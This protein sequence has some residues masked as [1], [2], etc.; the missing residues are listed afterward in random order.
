M[1]FL[2][3]NYCFC[4]EFNIHFS[5]PAEK[6][7]R[8]RESMLAWYNEK[9]R[10]FTHNTMCMNIMSLE[11][12]NKFTCIF[13]IE[14]CASWQDMGFRWSNRNAFMMQ[15]KATLEDLQIGYSLPTQP[16]YTGNDIPVELR[17]FGKYQNYGAKGYVAG[18][19]HG[20][21]DSVSQTF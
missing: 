3:S 19:P 21:R 17:N 18:P 9:P 8:L 5:T 12:M 2:S 20:F 6:I 1:Y 11:N 4:L 14:H 15:L 16:I 7:Y 13:Y 10:S